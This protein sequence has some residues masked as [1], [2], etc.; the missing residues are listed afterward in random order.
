MSDKKTI[1]VVG[2]TGAQGGGVARAILADPDGGFTVRA[3]TRD[4]S[5]EANQV[6][7]ASG[8]STTFLYTSFYWEN[9]I[10]FGLGPQRG[11]NGKLAITYPL[12]TA[13]MPAIAAEDIGKVAY[14]I[15]KAGSQY[16]GTS[17]Y[18]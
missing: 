12:G 5:K 15:F 6:L 11:E 13:Q 3:V 10:F 16:I 4:P 17:V 2:A 14:A 18:I 8:V 1:A 7:T 9:F